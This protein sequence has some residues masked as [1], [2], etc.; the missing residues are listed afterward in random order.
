[1]GKGATIGG[2]DIND[3]FPHQVC[4]N[5]DRRPERWEQSQ[6]EFAR[7]Q[8]KFVRRFPALDGKVLTIPSHWNYTPG[9]YGCLLSHLEI[10]REA[11]E[12]NLSS[13]L[14]FEDDVALAA[15]FRRHS[16]GTSGK[17]RLIGTCCFSALSMT[18]CRYPCPRTFIESAGLI[19]RSRMR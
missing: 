11:R 4:I 7:H 1:M 6:L 18:L 9:A 15:D 2:T 14:I 10:V 19:R 13:I 8:I 16:R 3:V 12:R 17:C 5:L